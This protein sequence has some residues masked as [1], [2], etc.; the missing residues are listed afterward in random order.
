[1]SEKPETDQVEQSNGHHGASGDIEII[2]KPAPEDQDVALTI[3]TRIDSI[4]NELDPHAER[5]LVRKI[6][7]HVIPLIAITYFITYIDKSTLSYGMYIAVNLN[8]RGLEMLTHFSSC[9]LWT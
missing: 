1:M 2:N 3:L 7:R 9:S 6:D 4:T 5:R 8:E